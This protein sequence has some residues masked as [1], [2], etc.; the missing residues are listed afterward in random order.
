MGGSPTFD[1]LGALL[2]QAVDGLQT[3]GGAKGILEEIDQPQS[4]KRQGFFQSFHQTIGRRFVDQLQ[5][6]PEFLESGFRFRAIALKVPIF[7]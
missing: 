6:R 1:L 4:V 2:N 3:V 5:F 7:Q